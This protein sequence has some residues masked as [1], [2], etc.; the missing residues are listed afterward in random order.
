MADGPD[1]TPAP[2]LKRRFDELDGLRGVAI[3][4]ITL[5]HIWGNAGWGYHGPIATPLLGT[6]HIGVTWFF[7]ISGFLLTYSLAA[8]DA[9]GE[10]RPGWRS[11]AARR[12]L[13]I[14]PPLYVAC[15]VWAAMPLLARGESLVADP[16]EVLSHFTLAYVLV[17]GLYL[18]LRP[19]GY[20]FVGTICHLYLLF[21]L[22]FFAAGRR[23]WAFVVFTLA[24]SLVI[25]TWC[26]APTSPL[27]GDPTLASTLE[28]SALGQ[29]FGFSAGIAVGYLAVRWLRQGRELRWGRALSLLGLAAC[30]AYPYLAFRAEGNP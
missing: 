11:F 10:P 1:Q 4:M 17:P 23:L 18:G 14:L 6:G 27:A 8:A 5:F 20:W 21:P 22:L 9:Q 24:I 3:I 16:V 30:I 29:L 15:A 28:A 13:R 7:V 26:F 19:P 2:T 12:A 25:R